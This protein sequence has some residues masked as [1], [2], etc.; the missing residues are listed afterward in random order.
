MLMVA[1]VKV[2]GKAKAKIMQ[3]CQLFADR[4][5]GSVSIN[6]T[7]ASH[8]AGA[9]VGIDL[10][11]TY[12]C[13]GVWRNDRVEIIANEQGNR[14]TPSYVAFTDAERLI[15][16]GA[17]L[18]AAMNA[19]N[20]VFD[21]KRLIG[22]L[23]ADST[24]AADMASWPFA[25]VE[26]EGKPMIEV[27]FRGETKVFSPE[28]ISSMVLTK[29]KRVAEAYL[30]E[31]VGNAVVTV[32]AY[33]NDAQRQATKDAGA[34]AGLN[35]LRIINEPTAAA[36]AYGLHHEGAEKNVLI[37]DLGGGTFDVSVLTI[38]NGIF[39]VKATAGDAHLGGEDFDARLVNHFV[40]E[41]K[42]KHR[43][44]VTGNARAMRRLRSACER[45]KRT[46]SASTNASIEI[47]AF[48]EGV[49]FY[50]SITRA[51]FEE[52]NH[53]LFAKC[54]GPV[55]RALTDAK[56]AKA[57]IHDIVLVGGSTR[58]P[59]VRALLAD[60]FAGRAPSQGINPDEAVAHGAAV[61]AAVLSGASDTSGKLA[62]L[63]LLDMTPFSL[64]LETAGGLMTNLIPRN[65]T[66]PTK[67]TQIFSTYADDQPGV[68][69]QV[70]EGERA[71]TAD[72]N[73]LGKFELT[74][75]APMPRGKPQIEVVFD[76]DAD[77]ILNVLAQDKSSGHK[78]S[79]KITND[80]ARLSKDDIDRMVAESE[81][82]AAEDDI[83]RRRISA[84]NDLEAA[85]F[86]LR[87]AVRDGTVSATEPDKA[88]I[89]AR[90][91]EAIAWLDANQDAEREE[92]EAQAKELHA[93]VDSIAAAPA[94][95]TPVV[96]E[97]ELD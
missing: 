48:Y 78:H 3:K 90:I 71:Q 96:N 57:D 73:L 70:F 58:I 22:R 94:A 63:L 82:Y 2:K 75:I 42:R 85:V 72:N 18:Q 17:K 25:V 43:A 28:Q 76:I 10:G 9:S 6:P 88:K 37:F 51:R 60:Y 87:T 7:M 29:M 69:I 26:H 65:T 53:D 91:D 95:P 77:G 61:H 21:A 97:S 81:K 20:T 45:A 49:D 27:E 55:E 92:F 54:I 19:K 30:G 31:D 66:I 80:S 68:L 13:V 16:D 11:T 1:P 24:V 5:S 56:L 44:D 4:E 32:P 46:L 79:I 50:S 35:V 74:G 93:F 15:G 8:T 39:E 89:S 33:F 38:D 62:E 52:L 64:G 23:F 83:I 47:D 12:S 40:R 67:K 86:S 14:T 84:R 41:F 36:I 59:R 34:I